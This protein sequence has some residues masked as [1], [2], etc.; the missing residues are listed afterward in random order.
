MPVLRHVLDG[1]ELE[2][3][4]PAPGVQ[5]DE[6]VEGDVERV[7]VVVARQPDGGAGR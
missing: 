4:P 7:L 3:P 1:G 6:L 2:L 5:D